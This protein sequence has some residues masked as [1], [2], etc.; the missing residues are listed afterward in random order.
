[1]LK[2]T[3]IKPIIALCVTLMTTLCIYGQKLEQRPN[4]I[5]IMSDDHAEQAISAYGHPISQKAPTPH[6]DRIAQEGALFVNNYCSNSICGP[7][8]AAILT[9]K[10][11]HKNGF[12]RNGNKGFDGTQ[13]TLPKI[14]QQ[15]GYQTAVIGKWHLIS[16]PTGFD[17]W[18][19]LNDQGDYYN[20]YFI[21]AQDT[22][23]RMGY[24]TDLITDL[25]K[26]WLANRDQNKPFFLM[27]HHKAPHRNWVPAERHYKLYEN[28]IFPVPETY[29]DDYEGRYAASQQEMNIYRDMYEGH[30]LKMVDGIDS[31]TLLYDPWPHAFLETMTTAERERFFSAYSDRNNDYYTTERT[32]KEK[33]VWKFQRYMQDYFATVKSVDESVGEIMDYLKASGLDKNTIIIYTSDQGFYL[34]EHGWFD[35]RFMYEESFCMPLLMAHPGYIQPGTKV[36]GLTQNIDF[37]PTLLDMCHIDIPNDMQ[38]LSFKKLVRENKTPKNWRKSLYYH[39]YEYP[40]FH[41]VRVHYGVKMERYKLMHFPKENLWEL[42]DLKKDPTETNNIYGTKIAEKITP[43]LKQELLMLQT[44]YDVDEKYK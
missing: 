33:A 15:N 6:I 9:G 27:M 24:V 36:D 3:E 17:H 21:T 4:V 26:E 8:R 2:K 42:Y 20:P 18:E 10:H 31:E 41:S 22:V 13:E 43:Q 39:Y 30:D 35:K 23:R 37:A 12:M 5:F 1:M 16:K 19:I 7:S 32:E 14:L 38:G 28:T 29:F 25:T 44:K 34:G 11:S 40:G